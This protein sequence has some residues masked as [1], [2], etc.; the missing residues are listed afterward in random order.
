MSASRES[1]IGF[2]G[3][4]DESSP[5]ITLRRGKTELKVSNAA[6]VI[7]RINEMYPSDNSYCGW[8]RNW[9]RVKR[10]LTEAE[11]VKQRRWMEAAKLWFKNEMFGGSE[12]FEVVVGETQTPACLVSKEETLVQTE[13]KPV[14]PTKEFIH[15]TCYNMEDKKPTLQESPVVHSVNKNAYE[16]RESIIEKSI[17]VVKMSDGFISGDV[18]LNVD[19]IL[20]VANKF[21]EFV[22]NKNRNK[23]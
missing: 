16:I 10:E 12:D 21:Y 18:K 19:K 11:K 23:L 5:T 20:Q 13:A 7:K 17:E 9:N 1:E 8:N 3:S 4:S 6:A 14:A 15:N 22:E 2:G